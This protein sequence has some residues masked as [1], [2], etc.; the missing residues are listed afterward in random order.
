LLSTFMI[1]AISFLII[2]MIKE[3]INT[4][5]KK[6][7]LVDAAQ[8][9]LIHK[10]F[11]VA[12]LV[13][14]T[15][16]GLGSLG[17]NLT[18]LAVFSGAIGLGIGLGLQA[19]ILNIL[20]GFFLLLDRSIKPGD[21]IAIGDTFG[22][23]NSLKSRYISIITR[24]GKEHLI[25]N[26]KFITNPVENWSY[27]SKSV[28]IKVPVTVSYESDLAQVT[29]LME[30]SVEGLNRVLTTPSPTCLI[31]AFGDNGVGM[32]LRVWIQDPDNGVSN[33]KSTIYFNIW[34]TFKEHH[35]EIPYPQLDLY[36]KNKASITP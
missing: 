7:N 28:R 21:V 32:E 12:T 17:F 8:K 16:I 26:E 10:F 9:I 1:V 33:L 24:D 13:I 23:V 30:Q 4:H 19:V 35:I 22:W 27:S 5:L 2:N 29:Q 18:T 34:R 11:N 20:S 14:I 31:K 25:P 3:R 15:F 36:I 6:S